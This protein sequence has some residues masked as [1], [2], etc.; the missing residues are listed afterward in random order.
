[1][2]DPAAHHLGDE[3][4]AT[5]P[6]LNPRQPEGDRLER[7]IELTEIPDQPCFLVL[8]VFQ[9]LGE[10]NDAGWSQR[11]REGELRTYV[12]INGKRIDYLNRYVKKSNDVPEQIAV[13]IPKGALEARKKHDT[14]GTDWHGHQGKGTGR[15]RASPDGARVSVVAKPWPRA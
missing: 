6:L 9:L 8:D 2:I 5:A 14:A 7:T 15:F 1:M 11:I 13:P 12:A 4:S 3:Y 10:D